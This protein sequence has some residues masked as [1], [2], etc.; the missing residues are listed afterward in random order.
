MCEPSVVCIAMPSWVRAIII[1]YVIDLPYIACDL[2][3][4]I[5]GEYYNTIS[6][7]IIE[8][9]FIVVGGTGA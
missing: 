8:A 4:A 5:D 6:S 2:L 9:E 3:H 7:I 1:L